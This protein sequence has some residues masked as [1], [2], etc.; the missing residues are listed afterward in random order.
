MA[1]LQFLQWLKEDCGYRD[2][3][4]LPGGRYTAIWPLMFT[5]AII[6]GSIGCYVGYD[7]RWC[8]ESYDQA[9]AALESWDGT[10]EPAGWHRHPTSGRRRVEGEPSS[11]YL[12][13]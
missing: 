3:R 9:K 4:P 5:H 10:G 2:L 8:Y 7:D 12:A 11:E 6:V 13:P 1:E